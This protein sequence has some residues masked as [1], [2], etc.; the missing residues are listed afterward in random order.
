MSELEQLVKVIMEQDDLAKNSDSWLYLR[1]LFFK[2]QESGINLNKTYV[3]SFITN[4][5]GWGLPEFEEVKK[6]KQKVLHPVEYR[7]IRKYRINRKR[8]KR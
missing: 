6:S 8:G 1:V 7:K 3:P 4:M 2:A 5:K